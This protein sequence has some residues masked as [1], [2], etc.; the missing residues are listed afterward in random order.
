VDE[1]RKEFRR[2]PGRRIAVANAKALSVTAAL[3]VAILGAYVLEVVV[4][5]PA[6]L[7]SGPSPLKLV[8]LGASVGLAQGPGSGVVGIAAGQEWRLFT[9]MFLHAGL[10]H[11]GF[12]AYALWIFGQVV[13]VELGRLR[14][15]VIYLVTG[16]FAGAASYAFAPS[17]VVVGVGASGAIFGIFGAF[18]A[19]NWRRRHTALA[20]ARLRGAVMILVLNAVIGLGSGGVIDWRAHLGGF[21]A[22]LAAGAAAE[23]F[24]LTR[25][26]RV[27]FVIGCVI[28][29]AATVGLVLWRTAQIRT[30]FTGLV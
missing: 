26:A 5:G 20:A 16:L 14:F 24:G 7:M 21:V 19:Y 27:A 11:L 17:P 8:E 2:G 13:E 9:S 12:N 29:A 18:V 28:L 6:A 22:G 15:L 23:G 4:G 10:L 3:L 25:N 1:A 30:E